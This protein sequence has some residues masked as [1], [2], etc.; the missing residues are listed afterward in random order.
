[1]DEGFIAL[2]KVA[3]IR[4]LGH[5][6]LPLLGGIEKITVG[7][8]RPGLVSDFFCEPPHPLAKISSRNAAH[9][10]PW[11]FFLDIGILDIG[12]AFSP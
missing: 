6:P 12:I 4:A 5:A 10:I 7:G 9:Q 11:L 3:V 8:A 1:M 2:L